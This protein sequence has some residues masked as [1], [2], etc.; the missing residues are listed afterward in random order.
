MVLADDDLDVDAEV[1]RRAQNFDDAPHGRF[2]IFQKFSIDDQAIKLRGI[3]ILFGFHADAIMLRAFRRKRVFHRNLHPVLYAGV[4][5]NHPEAAFGDPKFANNSGVGP[6]HHT[7]DFAFGATSGADTAHADN[8]A[9]SVHSAPNCIPVQV[10]ITDDTG[11]RFIGNEETEAIPM[12]R[13]ASGSKFAT[14]GRSLIVALIDLDEV[15][16]VDQGFESVF[17][18]YSAFTLRAEVFIKV[19]EVGPP[20]RELQDVGEDRRGFENTGCSGTAHTFI[21]GVMRLLLIFASTTA[22]FAQGPMAGQNMVAQNTPAAAKKTPVTVT[23]AAAPAAV[24]NFKLSGSPAATITIEVYTD[25]ECPS[26]RNLYLQTLPELIT[27][28]VAKGK[29]QLLHRDFPLPQHQYSKIATRYANAAGQLGQYDIVANQLFKTQAEWSQNGNVDGT[30]AKVV[31]P[32]DLQKIRDLVKNDTH[33]DDTVT[34]DV[35]M[36]NKDGLN[37]TPTLVVVNKG[38]RQKIDGFVPFMILKSYIDQQLAKN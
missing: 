32:G 30:V 22:L 38:K 6:A 31:A 29:V 28:Y 37:Q 11:N 27:Q 19:F 2:A 17:E 33:L 24:K 3:G 14:Q 15:P 9:I 23:K 20:L 18:R 13:D 34:T 26:C 35:A 21:I 12:N 1:I 36:A 25:Y 10:D 8:G 16:G 5:G 7:V 4:V